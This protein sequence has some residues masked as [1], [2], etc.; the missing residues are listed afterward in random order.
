LLEEVGFTGRA[1]GEA[2]PFGFHVPE[3]DV[4][5][6][7]QVSEVVERAQASSDGAS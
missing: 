5:F 3:D 6:L 2:L 4:Q 1:A 7:M